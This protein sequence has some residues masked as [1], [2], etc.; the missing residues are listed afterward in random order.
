M[1]RARAAAARICILASLVCLACAAPNVKDSQKNSE[2]PA[3]PFT[4]RRAGSFVLKSEIPDPR[5][6]DEAARVLLET[7]EMLSSC[8]ETRP[9]RELII[10]LKRSELERAAA[11]GEDR[12][13]DT[14]P[15]WIPARASR[16][17]LSAEVAFPRDELWRDR[18]WTPDLIL[19]DSLR[20]SLSHEAAHVFVFN[21]IPGETNIPESLHEG[22]AEW[23][24]SRAVDA[25]FQREGLAEL[26]DAKSKNRLPSIEDVLLTIPREAE[27]PQFATAAA[28]QLFRALAAVRPGLPAEWIYSA[29]A[30]RE[31]FAR[32][33]AELFTND[34][35]NKKLLDHYQNFAPGEYWQMGR[36]VSRLAGTETL[37]S[38]FLLAPMPGSPVWLFDHQERNCNNISVSADVTILGGGSPEF[39]IGFGFD[40]GRNGCRAV[41]PISGRATVEGVVDGQPHYGFVEEFGPGVVR[42]GKPLAVTVTRKDNRVIFEIGSRTLT[43]PIRGGIPYARGRIGIGARGGAVAVRKLSIRG[44]N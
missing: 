22:F 42:T 36:D 25:A 30:G 29:A 28:C 1:N 20:S 21:T 37:A 10:Y 23:I 39:W 31:E 5:V 17:A 40:D 41:I 35:L 9:S 16:S 8:L 6:C 7:E 26:Y 43:L 24:A 18:S 44:G 14:K 12:F 13:D 19:P 34:E 15:K 27:S 4:I 2:P 3:P 32:A 33:L 11:A 38:G